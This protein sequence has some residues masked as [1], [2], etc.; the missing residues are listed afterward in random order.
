MSVAGLIAVDLAGILLLLWVLNLVRLGR[1]Y[2]GYGVILMMIVA[3]ALVTLSWTPLAGVADAC[4][5]RLFPS[6]SAAAAV[7]GVGFFLVMLVYVLGQITVLSNRLA[8][9]VQE[10]AIEKAR[11][12][13]DRAAGAEA[14]PP[15]PPQA[16][17]AGE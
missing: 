15:G 13:T 9:L 8:I 10:L 5:S 2:V 4:L 12:R 6:P 7:L 14:D 3:A 1:L 11:Q 16:R 17:T